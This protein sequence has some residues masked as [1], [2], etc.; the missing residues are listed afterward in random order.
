MDGPPSGSAGRRR[1]EQR[2]VLAVV[3]HHPVEA[4]AHP[5]DLARGA[6]LVERRR[7]VA[8]HAPRE[9]LRL[10]QRDGKREPLERD[11]RPRS[12]AR[13]SMP[14]HDGR[15]RP[16]AA[17]SAGSTWRRRTASARRRMRRVT[18]RVAPLALDASGAELAPDEEVAGLERQEELLHPV[19]HEG[20]AVATSRVERAADRA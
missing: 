13:R 12:V 6:E 10:P 20:V 8:R 18:L 1:P 4:R 7:L 17:C 14:C 3:E 9:D 16:S 19:E 11:E 2:R 5:D 15:K